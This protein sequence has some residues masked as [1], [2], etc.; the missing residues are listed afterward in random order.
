MKIK[1]KKLKAKK[2]KNLKEDF[3]ISD[4]VEKD[5]KE[6]QLPK[7][8]QNKDLFEFYPKIL[9]SISLFQNGVYKT[10]EITENLDKNKL[11]N[12]IDKHLFYLVDKP[13]KKISE[14]DETFPIIDYLKKNLLENKTG[15]LLGAFYLMEEIKNKEEYQQRKKVIL[16]LLKS[17]NK[18]G[19][20]TAFLN[21][22][23]LEK[24]VID[25]Y[26]YL[27]K[28]SEN[29]AIEYEIVFDEKR[30]RELGL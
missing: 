21:K 6:Q 9:K 3:S 29:N 18:A 23:G 1:A 26:I 20:E 19:V 4:D 28:P 14:L 16:D 22:D 25:G 7:E 17:K 5:L 8:F 13:M 30:L 15:S 10:L 27:L 12:T 24:M 11:D 2:I